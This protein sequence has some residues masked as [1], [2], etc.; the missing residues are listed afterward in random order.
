ML[1]SEHSENKKI[2]ITTA[3]VCLG[4]HAASSAAPRP[5]DHYRKWD[6]DPRAGQRRHR[7]DGHAHTGFTAMRGFE[8]TNDY[9]NHLG[10]YF[11]RNW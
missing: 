3:E 9:Y 7:D 2:P 8:Y 1:S 6:G 5:A 10:V 11:S 4:R